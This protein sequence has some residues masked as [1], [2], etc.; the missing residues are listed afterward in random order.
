MSPVIKFVPLSKIWAR[1]PEE[2]LFPVPPSRV[3]ENE[4]D[5]PSYQVNVQL[6]HGTRNYQYAWLYK[7]L[8]HIDNVTGCSGKMTSS[9]R[10][11]PVAT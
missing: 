4:G 1:S 9:S 10:A 5:F 8:S 6:L 2:A 11:A 3:I 7:T